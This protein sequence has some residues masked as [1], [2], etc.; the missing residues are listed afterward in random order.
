[1][2][3]LIRRGTLLP[4]MTGNNLM[5]QFH[6]TPIS[7]PWFPGHRPASGYYNLLVPR[8]CSPPITIRDCGWEWLRRFY[9]I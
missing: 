5:I 8:V 3:A 1:M 6:S 7:E 2:R 4:I 9:A